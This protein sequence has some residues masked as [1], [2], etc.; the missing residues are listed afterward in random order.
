VLEPGEH[1]VVDGCHALGIVERLEEA[2]LE[3]HAG[4]ERILDAG[5]HQHLDA[6]FFHLDQGIAHVVVQGR[7]HAVLLF[8][9]IELDGGDVAV[10][11]QVDALVRHGKGPLEAL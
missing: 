1:V 10:D 8:R 3:V 11:R 9:P 6:R 2:L 4:T 7:A 5:D